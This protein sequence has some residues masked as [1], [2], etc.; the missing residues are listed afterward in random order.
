[1]D[2]GVLDQEK[3]EYYGPPS[4]HFPGFGALPWADL[5]LAYGAGTGDLAK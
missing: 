4:E 5:R 1:M 2:G 3:N